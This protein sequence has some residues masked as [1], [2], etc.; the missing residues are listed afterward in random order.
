MLPIHETSRKWW[1]NLVKARHNLF[2]IKNETVNFY[3]I[4]KTGLLQTVSRFVKLSLKF[5]FF[6]EIISLFSLKKAWKKKQTIMQTKTTVNLV[7][8][9]L[10]VYEHESNSVWWEKKWFKIKRNLLWLE[11][12][13]S[14]LFFSFSFPSN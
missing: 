5:V 2:A 8:R 6:C 3:T 10:Y 12:C 11:K 1:L 4:F 13:R 14:F 7:F 9:H